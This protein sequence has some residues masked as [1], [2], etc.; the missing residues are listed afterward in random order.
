MHEPGPTGY[1]HTPVVSSH[2]SAVHDWPSEQV[3]TVAQSPEVLHAP[4]PPIEP[5]LQRAP[6]RAVHDV[7]LETGSHDRHGFVGSTVPPA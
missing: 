1:V 4:Q 2:V 3:E 6:V 5:S 7:E